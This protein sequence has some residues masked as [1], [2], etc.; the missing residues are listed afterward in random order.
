MFESSA[1]GRSPDISPRTG[2]R[3]LAGS[4]AAPARRS[5][6]KPD[7]APK[8]A[9]SVF[10]DFTR[11]PGLAPAVSSA[12]HERSG[13]G[14][15]P[16]EEEVRAEPALPP[17]PHGL[18]PET[19]RSLQRSAGNAA[20][21]RLLAGRPLLQRAP[22]IDATDAAMGQRIVD[23]L[24][25]ANGPRTAQT[26]VHYAHNYQIS[27]QGGDAFAKSFWKEEYWSGYADPR[28]W[29]RVGHMEWQLKPMM[30]AAAAIKAW[31][32]GLTIA[33]CAS[34][35]VAIELD[36]LR[37]AVGDQRFNQMY[38]ETPFTKPERELLHITQFMGTSSAGAF[39]TSTDEAFYNIFGTETP[40]NRTVKK[41]EWYYFCNHPQYLL[42][43]PGGAFQGENSVCMDDTKGAQKWSGFGVGIKTEPEM[44]D[45]MA[46]AYNAARSERDYEVIVT[47][48]APAE[49]AT[50]NPFVT[51]ESVYRNVYIAKVPPAYWPG[52]YPDQVDAKAI[53]DAPEVTVDGTKRKGGFLSG[54]GQKLD[55]AKVL[56]ARTAPLVI[57]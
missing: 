37:A 4:I 10:L 18:S 31:L 1:C 28:F 8:F 6:F 32:A 39:K 27:A 53:N 19:V 7:V 20:V 36:T 45:E 49:A 17:A 54:R 48:F 25:R 47:R 33:E 51:W 38:G 5:L 57:F 14:E 30:N 42:K 16:V 11:V 40:G 3:G 34:V 55:P 41:G 12:G 23:D 15:R 44:L 29:T 13:R 43:H 26:G 9:R 24:N 2:E 21:G 50:K 35:L 22:E 56:D 52:T 46:R